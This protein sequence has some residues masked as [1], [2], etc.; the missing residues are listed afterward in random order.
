MNLIEPSDPQYFSNTSSESYERHN[1]KIVDKTGKSVIV[2]NWEMAQMTWFQKGTF[3]SHIEVLDNKN[4]KP[5]GFS[6]YA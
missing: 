3:L 6:N 5:K 4:K 2:D 1:Y